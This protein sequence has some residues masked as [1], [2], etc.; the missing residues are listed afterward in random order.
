[1]VVRDARMVG[2]VVVAE[3][4]LTCRVPVLHRVFDALWISIGLGDAKGTDFGVVIAEV[5]RDSDDLLGL[6][7]LGH[8]YR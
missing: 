6:I 7:V 1:M 2:E 8:S 4:R 5:F 3:D